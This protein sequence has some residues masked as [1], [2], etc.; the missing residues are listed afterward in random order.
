MTAFNLDNGTWSIWQQPTYAT[1][2]GEAAAKDA[3]MY[4][5]VSDWNAL[6]ANRKDGFPELLVELGQD[7]SNRVPFP[8]R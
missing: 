7:I 6:A 4:F 5:N 3:D 8:R 1:S 2:A